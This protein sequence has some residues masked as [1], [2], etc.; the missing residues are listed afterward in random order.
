MVEKIG[1][2]SVKP[3]MPSGLWKSISNRKYDQGE[4][5][6]L[7][8]RSLY[9]YWMRT[10]PPPTMMAFNAAEREV[11]AVR[12]DLTTTPLQ[13]LTMMN[14]ITFIEAGR[15]IAER[16]M[17]EGGPD[18]NQKLEFICKL[19]LSR[20]PTSTEREAL[21]A[22][23]TD[24]KNEFQNDPIGAAGL[25]KIGSSPRDASLPAPEVAAWTMV[26]NTIL[27]LD[28]AITTN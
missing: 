15:M 6:D 12:K 7:Y 22:N 14:N 20:K 11:C 23:Y 18:A 1:G 9:T 5:A 2:P 19:I 26:A 25:L 8:R 3:Y 10:I 16:T 17:R 13:A 24:F 28:E 4:G 21:I 27:N